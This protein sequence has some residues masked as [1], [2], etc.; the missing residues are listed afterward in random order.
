V[1]QHHADFHCVADVY[2]DGLNASS[3]IL[4]RLGRRPALL[5]NMTTGQLSIRPFLFGVLHLTGFFY[6]KRIILCPGI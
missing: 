4:Y 2:L 5:E 6:V 1:T 3:R